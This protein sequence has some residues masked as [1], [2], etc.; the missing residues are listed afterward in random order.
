MSYL[1]PDEIRFDL[2]VTHYYY[3]GA[4]LATYQDQAGKL[5]LGMAM[6]EMPGRD[7]PVLMVTWDEF[8]PPTERVDT[9]NMS[10]VKQMVDVGA[11]MRAATFAYL[12]DQS[13]NTGAETVYFP[14]PLGDNECPLGELWI[15]DQRIKLT[16]DPYFDRPLA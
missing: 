6:G 16:P 4:Q 13:T 7:W 11:G 5:W 15:E 10:I 9:D 8:S 2:V 1:P 12:S 3:D 14:T